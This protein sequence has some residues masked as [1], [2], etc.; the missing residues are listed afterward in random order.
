M[1][2]AKIFKNQSDVHS[3][4]AF[5]TQELQGS[6]KWAGSPLKAAFSVSPSMA[7]SVTISEASFVRDPGRASVPQCF[8]HLCKGKTPRYLFQLPFPERTNLNLGAW[9]SLTESC[10]HTASLKRFKYSACQMHSPFGASLMALAAWDPWH[11]PGSADPLLQCVQFQ[12]PIV[13]SDEFLQ[14]W[15]TQTRYG[16]SNKFLCVEG[17]LVANLAAPNQKPSWKFNAQKTTQQ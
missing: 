2:H 13:F 10:R 15:A 9:I 1:K 6:R 11:P 17:L 7:S 16:T 8:V 12:S 4:K 3:F 14:R 5:F